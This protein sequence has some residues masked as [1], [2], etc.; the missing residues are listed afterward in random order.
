MKRVIHVFQEEKKQRSEIKLK[1]KKAFSLY[2][3]V[4]RMYILDKPSFCD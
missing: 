1:K 4:H 3:E 2:A